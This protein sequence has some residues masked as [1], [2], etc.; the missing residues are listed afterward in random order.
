M[1]VINLKEIPDETLAYLL[2]IQSETKTEKKICQYSL[3]KT[4]YKIIQEHKEFKKNK[5]HLT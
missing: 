2:K 4:V 5:K 1:A 3:E